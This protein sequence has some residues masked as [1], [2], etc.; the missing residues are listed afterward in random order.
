[1]RAARDEEFRRYV[2]ARRP[3]LLR[4]ATLLT[5]GD[6]HL[7]EDV[8]QATLTRL[9]L[10]WPAFQ[11]AKNPNGYARRALVNAMVDERR[12]PWRREHSLAELPDRPVVDRSSGTARGD[13]LTD[14]LGRLPPRMRAAVVF[15][16]FHDLSVTDTA[17]AL[18][19]SEGTV[20]SQTARALDR[21][22]DVMGTPID[23][24]AVPV[25]GVRTTSFR[26]ATAP[27]TNFRR[28]Y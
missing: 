1:M 14:A 17:D 9:Y 18:G 13:R 11:K 5:A 22:R 21:L 23:P 3:E 25:P 8:V 16:Y 15:R 2:L 28:S 19:C 20:K 7:A 4:T 24:P 10:A 27:A 12:R 6:R 26:P